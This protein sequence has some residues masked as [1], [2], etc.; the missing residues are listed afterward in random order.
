MPRRV[1]LILGQSRAARAR[2]D[3]AQ[4]RE[5]TWTVD[6]G[7]ETWGDRRQWPGRQPSAVQT[8]VDLSRE[9]QGVEK[10]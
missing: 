2:V 3:A 7:C 4:R 10:A 5:R 1:R 9:R 6:V 8:A